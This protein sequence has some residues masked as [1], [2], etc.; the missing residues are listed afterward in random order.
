MRGRVARV[1]A[2][3]GVVCCVAVAHLAV[4]RAQATP[5]L[6]KEKRR[7]VKVA[8]APVPPKPM[9]PS[10]APV[11]FAPPPA[12]SEIDAQWKLRLEA[13]A[14]GDARAASAAITAI[15]KIRLDLGI[16][17]LV[18]HAL[19]LLREARAAIDKSLA[20]RAVE[21]C[22]EA[23]RLAPNY[24]ALHSTLARAH[25]AEDGF[26]LGKVF[27][28][29]SKGLGQV[30]ADPRFRDAVFANAFIDVGLALLCAVLAFFL[31]QVV[32]H[33]RFLHHDFG[34]LLG[35]GKWLTGGLLAVVLAL[36]WVLGLGP[37]GVL[38]LWA[39][40]FWG[41]QKRAERIV[42]L[43]MIGFVGLL[44]FVCQ[45]LA[46]LLAFQ[47]QLGADLLELNRGDPS[48]AVVQRA[49][50]RLERDPVEFELGFLLARHYK[51]RGQDAQAEAVYKKARA[52]RESHSALANNY[53]NLLL[54]T[55]RVNEAIPLYERALSSPHKPTI[56]TAQ[57]N[58]AQAWRVLAARGDSS[59][60][61]K[62]TQALQAAERA[63][64]E[65]ARALR[66]LHA[67]TRNRAAFDLPLPLGE[68]RARAERALGRPDA[69]KAQLWE[70]VAP[71]LPV[72]YAPFFLLGLLLVLGLLWFL[73]RE[74]RFASPCARCEAVVDVHTN[75][76]LA[77]G[78]HCSQCHQIYLRGTQLDPR[79]RLEKEADIHRQHARRRNVRVVLSAMVMG[80]GQVL[81]GRP[82]RG[83]ALLALFF[84][85]LME[86]VFWNG[87][88]RYPIG[89]D[90]SPSMFKATLLALVFLPAYLF[91]LAGVLR[92]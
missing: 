83:A 20:P 22:A 60:L 87:V 61:A 64:V 5:P 23:G 52:A 72:T 62:H 6:P 75:P 39:I 12:R 44:P 78:D 24:P 9:A 56:A 82:A 4:A 41:Y 85:L 80:A 58:L 25:F 36:P 21:L 47:S 7:A 50:Q 90:V 84:V 31:L 34:V 26:A 69:L 57:F 63:D 76:E 48:P 37:V 70:R 51:S 3:A 49:Q 19:A 13:L 30:L 74:R 65:T 45:L 16:A 92:R 59:A 53:A 18:P 33:V 27:G 54:V 89:T 77:M 28:D 55:G 11:T 79:L 38:A 91:G 42:G 32:R 81:A 40:L 2:L 71:W 10:V 46:P 14:R 88:V 15:D 68:L 35:A 1:L 66:G 17:E 8:P 43:S 86:L 29:L 73:L 67:P